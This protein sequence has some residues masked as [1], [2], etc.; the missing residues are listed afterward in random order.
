MNKTVK[1]AGDEYQVVIK[2]ERSGGFSAWS[3]DLSGC[4]SQG[5][6]LEEA[7]KNI[8]EAI[9]FYLEGIK[10]AREGTEYFT[11]EEVFG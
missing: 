9:K 10:E 4:A 3:P 7:L 6:T 1:I 2:K 5:E 8:E 11:H